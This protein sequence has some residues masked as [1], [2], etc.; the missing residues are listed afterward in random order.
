[1]PGKGAG[2]DTVGDERAVGVGTERIE[3]FCRRD[4]RNVNGTGRRPLA[5][6]PRGTGELKIA[7]RHVDRQRVLCSL[8]DRR[9]RERCM[10]GRDC[11][12]WRVMAARRRH[13]GP[14]ARQRGENGDTHRDHRVERARNNAVKWS[15]QGGY[16]FGGVYIAIAA[17]ML[18][19]QKKHNLGPGACGRDSAGLPGCKAGG[20]WGEGR[21]AGRLPYGRQA[22]A[23]PT[24]RRVCWR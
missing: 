18:P 23:C 16:P 13:H 22:E 2:A 7:R 20:A 17:A 5:A 3:D 9:R 11:T 4:R 6:L 24:W 8:K 12:G 10:P 15:L 14:D 19:Q 21:Q 1:M